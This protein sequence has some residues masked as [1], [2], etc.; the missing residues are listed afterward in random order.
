MLTIWK[1][2]I[3]AKLDYCSQLWCPDT[4]SSISKLESVAKNFTAQVS[5]L[6]DLDYWERLVELK[7]YSQ[8]R[9]RERYQIIY[10]WKVSQLLVKGYN[11]PF[12]YNPRRGT[13]VHLP[14]IA[15]GCPSSVKKARE[16]SLRVKGAKLF[17]LIPKELR[18]LYQ[19]GREQP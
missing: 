5:G 3:Q 2:L 17:N 6:K 12:Y 15:T 9:R 11:L 19:A 10:I 4:Q 18:D 1:S 14:P 13:L 8:E 7:M 16:A